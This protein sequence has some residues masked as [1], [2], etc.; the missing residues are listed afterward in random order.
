[1]AAPLYRPGAD[2]SQGGG[3][4]QYLT[5]WSTLSKRIEE[6][7]T[8]LRG[9]A[10]AAQR[11]QLLASRQAP[12]G[13]GGGGTTFGKVQVSGSDVADYLGAKLS[14]LP[15]I[16]VN[17]QGSTVQIVHDESGV[18]AGTYFGTAVVDVYG[19]VTGYT[20]PSGVSATNTVN[21]NL[22]AAG[23]S[24]GAAAAFTF[25]SLV[26]DDL[27]ASGTSGKFLRGD[28]TWVTGLLV[29]SG[30]VTSSC[31][32][33][34]G[35]TWG[36]NT[37]VILG[38]D[39]SV[40]AG[41]NATFTATGTDNSSVRSLNGSNECSM[42]LAGVAN[43]FITGSAAGDGGLRVASG[44]VLLFGDTTVRLT[45]DGSGHATIAGYMKS[46]GQRVAVAT[47]TN[48]DYTLTTTDYMV[49]F[50]TGNTSRA[51]LLPAA[52]G[53]GQRYH[54]FKSDTGTGTVVIT[55]AGSDTINGASIQT[56][57]A[58]QYRYAVVTDFASGVWIMS[59]SSL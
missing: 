1:M 59:P 56:I 58:N 52:T 47:K 7:E 21:A 11:A 39:G 40:A 19:H 4:N 46:A 13:G 27:A 34:T 53:S 42:F 30:T 43:G 45:L 22:V 41:R 14:D 57:T 10:Q 28:M 24:S 32:R 16:S 15:P 49:G 31:L 55:R 37:A 17:P 29:P 38:G 18:T 36:E 35:T 51:A 33:W 3:Y 54:I 20:R 8:L 44:K 5:D 25:R 2:P 12:V 23:P 26:A 9:Q 50:S 6:L 48:T